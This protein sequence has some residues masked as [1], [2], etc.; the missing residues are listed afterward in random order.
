[1]RFPPTHLHFCCREPGWWGKL[2]HI[3]SRPQRLRFFW[4]DQKERGLWRREWLHDSIHFVYIYLFTILLIANWMLNYVTEYCHNILSRKKVHILNLIT[5]T[6]EPRVRSF[7][8]LFSW[9]ARGFS[10]L[11]FF[12]WQSSEG[13]FKTRVRPQGFPPECLLCEVEVGN[14]EYNDVP[15]EWVYEQ[16][17]R[18]YYG[19]FRQ[20]RRMQELEELSH[21][22]NLVMCVLWV[23]LATYKIT[24]KYWR[25]PENSSLQ[26]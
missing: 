19:H 15:K 9:V 17:Y 11:S 22:I 14:K 6:Y 3:I 4:S 24:F 25:K 5:T 18:E 10:N 7:I 16:K 12:N 23:I 26:R 13:F 8:A 2:T 1:M 21:G 20:V